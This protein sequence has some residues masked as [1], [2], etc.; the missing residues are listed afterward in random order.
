MELPTEKKPEPLEPGL[1]AA[2]G[3]QRFTPDHAPGEARRAFV[4]HYGAEPEHVGF[5][6]RFRYA[7]LVAG[8][9]PAEV[10]IV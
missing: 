4:A 3:W 8:P 7:T 5:D 6:T 9:V 1:L 10:V 2:H